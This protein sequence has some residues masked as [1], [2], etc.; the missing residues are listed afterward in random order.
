MMYGVHFCYLIHLMYREVS[1]DS[2]LNIVLLAFMRTLWILI[3]LCLL[4]MM[5]Y[6][7]YC[8]KWVKT[9]NNI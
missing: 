3:L 6:S 9:G 5:I 2:L 4:L 7:F 8:Q 1:Y